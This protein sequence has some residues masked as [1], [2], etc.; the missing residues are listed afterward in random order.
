MQVSCKQQLQSLQEYETCN[1]GSGMSSLGELV[2]FAKTTLFLLEIIA[3]EKCFAPETIVS[4]LGGFDRSTK[5]EEKLLS[6]FP[7]WLLD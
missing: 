7:N 2:N 6:M 5:R 3:V 4:V 1:E